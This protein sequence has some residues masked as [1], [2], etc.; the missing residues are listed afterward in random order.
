MISQMKAVLAGLILALLLAGGVSAQTEATQE[1]D[2]WENVATRAEAVV[3]EPTSTD[4]VLETLRS[5]ITT[6]RAQFDA[7]LLYTSPSPRD[8]G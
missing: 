6:F 5:R 7:C 2:L 4:T 3:A 1:I 8:R